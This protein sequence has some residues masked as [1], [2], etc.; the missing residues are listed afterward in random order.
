MS[1]GTSTTGRPA[2]ERLAGLWRDHALAARRLARHTSFTVVVGLT[3]GLTIGGN[4]AIYSVVNG[5]LLKPLPY[6]SPDQ[7]IRVFAQ[8]PRFN[9][10]PLTAADLH[11]FRQADHVFQGVAGYYREGHEFSGSAG[12]ENLEGLFVSAGYF[13]LLGAR[14]VLGRTLGSD[15]ERPGNADRV[16]VSDRIWRTRLGADRSIIGRSINLS[17]RPFVVV[18]VMPPGV[19]HVGGKQRSLPHGETADFW[20]PLTI[21]PADLNRTVR[22]LNTVARLRGGVSVDQANIELDRL[23][24]AQEQL[25]PQTHASWRATAVPLMNEIVGPARPVLLAIFGAVGCVLLIACGNVACLTL[26]RSIGRSREH[27]VRAALGASRG[28]IAREIFVESWLLAVLGACL[29]VPLAVAGVQ[30]LTRLAPPH[31]PRLHAIEVD[32]GMLF[33]GIALTF[34]TALLCGLLPA[35]Y[36]GRTHLEEAL[37]E[38]GRSGAPGAH[39]LGWHRAL[40]VGQLALCFVLLTSAGLLARTFYLVR[41]NPVGFRPD[42]V[43]TAT[44]DLPGAVTRYGRDV[45]ERAAFH[46]TLLARLREQ[47]GVI[48]AGSAA[49]LPFAAQLDSTDSQGLVRFMLAERPT[50]PDERPFARIEI[51]STGYLE[52]LGVPLLEGRAFDARDTL[53]SAPVALVSMELVRRYFPG[54]TLVGKNLAGGRRPPTIV[55]VVAD[56]KATALSVRPE[57]IVYIPM[58]QSPLFRTRLAVRT[59]GDP[60]ALLPAIRR[61]V[62]AIDP[63]L[64]VFEVKP[65]AQIAADAVATQRFAL[66]LFGLFA[67]LALG[68]SVI[69]VYGVLAYAVAHRLPEFGVRAALGASPGLLLGMILRQG[70]RMGTIGIAFGIGLSLLVTRLL[71]GLLFGVRPFDV[72]TFAVVAVL[73]GV[74]V[75]AAC[76][77][78]ARRAG[79]VDPMTTLRNV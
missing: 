5:V 68:L 4:A 53:A 11:A 35:W 41:H 65:L 48:S 24:R 63:D 45:N 46:R 77:L 8:H 27:A 19:E 57:P 10:L 50:P 9:D 37:R 25:W 3:L 13:E 58:E 22:L 42:G 1:N 29:G 15:D 51:V 61:V 49:R 26:A 30:A 43:L 79:R 56:V 40:V 75:V 2:V 66:L 23:A 72:P 70:I 71:D 20:I 6:P 67:G 76:L 31:L 78:P 55:G 54:D 14:A 12:P 62:T 47:P 33:F 52:T 44:F 39:S 17:R 36:G 64:P 16:V 60:Q 21:N 18:G 69:G 7:L 74:V 38:G 28:R 34:A 59:H 73:F 32:A